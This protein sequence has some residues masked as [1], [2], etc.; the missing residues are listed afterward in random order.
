MAPL[1]TIIFVSKLVSVEIAYLLG[2]QN[3]IQALCYVIA[4]K[5]FAKNLFTYGRQSIELNDGEQL[6]QATPSYAGN[7]KCL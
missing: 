1:F 4:L 5:V 3:R 6:L 7:M 2:I